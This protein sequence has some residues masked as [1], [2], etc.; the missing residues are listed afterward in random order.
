MPETTYAPARAFEYENGFYL[1]A[2]PG[3]L[4]KLL[5][6]YELYKRILGLP[7]EVVECG[8]FKG[9][10]L[11]RLATFRDLLESPWSRRVIGF[12]TFGEN[13]G[14][15]YG[16]D[17]PF[18]AGFLEEAGS[19]SLGREELAGVLRRKGIGNFE[20]VEGD[21]LETVPDYAA[22]HPELRIA[23]L[24]I[25]T[26]VREPAT[27]VLEQ[28][29]ERI[30]PGGLLVLDDYGRFPGETSAAEEFLGPRNI[31]LR[32]LGLSHA[33]AYAVKESMR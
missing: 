33:P 20:L 14:T 16:P 19:R 9:A 23:L 32:K 17:R 28:F 5:A 30:V 11:V 24:H 22:R 21:I 7:G 29:F 12:D 2:G 13:P 3:R 8:V 4:G 1:A 27:V 10:S 6:H 31:E 25:D 15:A 18:L 26:D